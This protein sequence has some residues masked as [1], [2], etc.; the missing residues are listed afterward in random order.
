M[1]FL[2]LYLIVQF[3]NKN[4]INLLILL[5][6]LYYFH[7]DIYLSLFNISF[8]NVILQNYLQ[9]IKFYN[10]YVIYL[11]IKFVFISKHLYMFYK[12]IIYM[13]LVKDLKKL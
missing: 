3:F 12:I 13:S 8:I 2:M 7:L 9:R 5:H 1:L 10:Y 4:I 11:E 6:I